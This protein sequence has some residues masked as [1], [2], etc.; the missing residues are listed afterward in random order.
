MLGKS[1]MI[2]RE[3]LGDQY[4]RLDPQLE[5][6]I[7]MDDPL[8]VPELTMVANECNLDAVFEW[9]SSNLYKGTV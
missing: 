5:R 4:F 6:E 7:S 2:C 3:I 8:V 9:I 1:E